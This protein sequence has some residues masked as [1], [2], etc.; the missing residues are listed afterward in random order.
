ME[1]SIKELKPSGYVRKVDMLGRLTLP[2]K[3]RNQLKLNAELEM[4]VD[5]E[6][7]I[8]QKYI[9]SCFFCANTE[10]IIY[11]KEKNICKKCYKELT[12]NLK[13]L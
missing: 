10:E 7:I 2:M 1:K 11:Y 4:Y 13:Q 8:V 12:A 9:Q 5:G 3:L 6:Q